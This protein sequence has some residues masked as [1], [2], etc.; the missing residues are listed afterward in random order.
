MIQVMLENAVSSS[1]IGGHALYRHSATCK[2]LLF[3][4]IFCDLH[5][6]HEKQSFLKVLMIRG[7]NVNYQY[8]RSRAMEK[9][10]CWC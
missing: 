2:H 1:L 4:Q 7:L 3:P 10:W 9:V 5:L 6:N 8:S